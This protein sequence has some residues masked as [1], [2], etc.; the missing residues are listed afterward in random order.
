VRNETT[1]TR[2]PAALDAL[3][4]L[5]LR[6][7][8]Q[9]G[10]YDT[11]VPRL[12]IFRADRPSTPT[13]AVYEP[14]LCLVLAGKKRG[15]FGK[16]VYR[17]VAGDA[18]LVS[19]D[20]PVVGTIVEAKPY[21]A[22]RFELQRATLAS[23]VVDAAVALQER[24]G[25]GRPV[26]VARADD[27]LLDALARLARLLDRPS[28]VAVLAPLLEREILFRLLTGPFGAALREL[29]RS[30]SRI[31]RI[32]RAVAW[33]RSHFA[34]EFDAAAI[35]ALASMSVPSFN[36]HFRAVTAMSP[37][38]YQKRVR[39]QEARRR[40]VA[41][42]GDVARVAFAVGYSSTSQFNREYR[43]LFGAPPARDA[44]RLRR[45]LSR[46]VERGRT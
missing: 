5:A 32:G 20:M 15:F 28:E 11:R 21:I 39:L 8:D 4:S 23:V 25:D 17:Y 31:A 43:R 16:E 36:R 12:G 14:M 44:E 18:L 3:R 42:D 29:A 30:E 46:D 45:E 9:P 10:A 27:D 22:L 37:L 2:L 7:F 19:V 34:S 1:T 24:E 6:H 26:H 33:L 35:A 40:I 13:P 41:E 38:E